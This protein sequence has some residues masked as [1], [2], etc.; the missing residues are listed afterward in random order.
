MMIN[1]KQVADDASNYIDGHLPVTK[2]LA[3]SLHLFI[4]SHCRRYL[5]Q[6]QST[7]AAVAAFK[8]REKTSS[9]AQ[10]IA[11]ELL[12]KCNKTQPKT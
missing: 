11:R 1:C 2:R 10:S 12:E 3:I 8:P 7:T 4:C 6:L 5:K 9:D